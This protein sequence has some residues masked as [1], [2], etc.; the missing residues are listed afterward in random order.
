MTERLRS[1]VVFDDTN[2]LQRIPDHDYNRRRTVHLC[3]T[4]MP[5]ERGGTGYDVRAWGSAF[6]SDGD[7]CFRGWIADVEVLTEGIAVVRET[8]QQHVIRHEHR[9]H[10]PD[11]PSTV[12]PFV[13]EHTDSPIDC[14]HL[15]RIGLRLARAGNHLFQL[16]FHNGDP[17]MKEIGEALLRHIRDGECIMTMESDHL[18]VPWNLLY[19]PPEGDDNQGLLLDDSWSFPGFWGHQHLIEHTISRVRGFDSRIPV[20]DGPVGI[21]L[22]VD[23]GVDEEYPRTRFVA[24]LHDIFDRCARETSI[25][26]RR[27]KDELRHAFQSRSY[28]DHISCFGCH[29][30]VSP[31]GGTTGSYFKLGDGEE[32]YGSEM[33]SW[34]SRE[35][36]MP[37]RP[38]VFVGACEGGQLSSV[39]YP[40]AG[41]HLL[42]NGARC[43]LGPQIDLPRAFAREYAAR[44]FSA[45]LDEGARLGDSVRELARYFADEEGN[46]L[47]LIFTLHRGLDVHLWPQEPV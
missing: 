40:T 15:D 18:F 32:I 14:P 24:E 19:T 44:L 29:G 41:H 10:G 17:G 26:V 22:N 28:D 31:N 5:G 27:D 16:L 36:P 43:L 4:R 9:G 8:W 33:A 11:A 12:F 37:G 47:G 20:H 3:F 46:P 34:L 1:T 39:F 25:A 23:E 13:D 30:Q 21:G 38:L 2:G 45:F 6:P 7:G 35:E 42:R